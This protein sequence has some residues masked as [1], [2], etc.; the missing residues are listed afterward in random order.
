MRFS[1]IRVN[2]DILTMSLFTD[3]KK[4]T[5]IPCSDENPLFVLQQDY[6]NRNQRIRKHR[7]PKNVNLYGNSDDGNYNGSCDDLS[8]QQYC[9]PENEI[10]SSIR[11]ATGGI[12]YSNEKLEEQWRI[13]QTE[14]NLKSHDTISNKSSS[15][16]NNNYGY[17]NSNVESGTDSSLSEIKTVERKQTE[18]EETILKKCRLN[19]NAAIRGLLKNHMISTKDLQMPVGSTDVGYKNNIDVQNTDVFPSSNLSEDTCMKLVPY[20]EDPDIF[21]QPIQA[22]GGIDENKYQDIDFSV[23]HVGKKTI[24]TPLQFFLSIDDSDF[25]F[26]KKDTKKKK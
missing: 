1:S 24:V 8:Q 15:S 9:L 10:A 21:M 22:Y 25:D 11:E 2:T 26:V 20:E 18:V 4:R 6:I 19:K 3:I 5:Q 16:I 14:A 7:T 12:D 23:P 13:R 17:N